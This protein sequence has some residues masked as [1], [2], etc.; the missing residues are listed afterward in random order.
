M[1]EVAHW[2]RERGLMDFTGPECVPGAASLLEAEMG[3]DAAAVAARQPRDGYSPEL[4]LDVRPPTEPA[5]SP[6]AV[7]ELLRKVSLFGPLLDREIDLLAQGAR[8]E[9][10]GPMDRLMHQGEEGT[11]LWIIESG[12]AEVLVRTGD[13]ERTLSTLGPGA[14]LGERG[15]LLGERR[16]ATVRALGEVV[17]L[18]LTHGSLQPILRARPQLVVELS[19]LLAARQGRAV[20]DAPGTGLADQI[21]RFFFRRG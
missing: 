12:E 19:L 14:I 16:G 17:A 11:S 5:F 15:L 20:A 18:E 13:E 3:G 6:R 9:R 1:N 10:F 2:A 8:R 4:S 21:R 7:G